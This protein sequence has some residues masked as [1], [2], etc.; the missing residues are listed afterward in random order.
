LLSGSTDEILAISFKRYFPV[1]VI[2]EAS[3][4]KLL[5][6]DTAAASFAKLKDTLPI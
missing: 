3:S 1:F 2:R 6:M 4:V 5:A